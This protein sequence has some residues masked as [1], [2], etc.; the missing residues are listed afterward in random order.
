MTTD[1]SLQEELLEEM[2]SP[3]DDPE[4]AVDDSSDADE[5]AT[6]AGDPDNEDASPE[7]DPPAEP[8][9]EEL[10]ETDRFAD[11]RAALERIVSGA[12]RLPPVIR[13]RLIDAIT[14]AGWND[15][16]A[17]QPA[18]T[19]SET[20]RWLE[21]SLPRQ[22]ALEAD[23]IETR[24]HPYGDRFFRGGAGPDDREADQIAAEQLAATGFARQ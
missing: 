22:F 7:A 3:A 4:P 16:G 5:S 17:E 10:P 2:F 15:D 12:T 18:L 1:Q 8:D 14:R 6:A 13:E 21:E 24:A 23:R 11:Q 20:V 19:V 9:A